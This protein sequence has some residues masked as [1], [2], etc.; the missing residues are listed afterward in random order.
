MSETYQGGK[1]DALLRPSQSSS[2]VLLPSLCVLF[3]DGNQLSSNTQRKNAKRVG[4]ETE[5]A[6]KETGHE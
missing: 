1:P 3:L 5:E 4:P 2:I 6:Q